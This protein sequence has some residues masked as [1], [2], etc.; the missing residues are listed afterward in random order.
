MP[1]QSQSPAP[2]NTS[3]DLGAGDTSVELPDGVDWWNVTVAE[4]KADSSSFPLDEW[5]PLL[6]HNT[7]C[8]SSLV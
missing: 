4:D 6:P 7:G 5:T 3:T 2:A 1:S 8:A